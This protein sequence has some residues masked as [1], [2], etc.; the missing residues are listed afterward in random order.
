[1]LSPRERARSRAW[2]STPRRVEA[3][4]TLTELF[5]SEDLTRDRAVEE[6][7]V[8]LAELVGDGFAA[9]LLEEEQRW[10]RPLG[11]HHPERQPGE[12][13]DAIGA[14]RFRA[15]QGFSASVLDTGA[16]VLIPRITRAEIDALQPELAPV[17]EA[18]GA[19]GFIIV[20][21]TVRGRCVAL[22]AQWRTRARPRLCEDDQRFLEEVGLRFALGL[23]SWSP[24][25]A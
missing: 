12:V 11:A 24:D 18:M 9:C 14:R 23:A 2:R 8:A 22:V 10:M 5:A 21:A 13:L 17:C 6:S 16:A 25:H 19:R 15:D 20:P 4:A 1:M 3:L 7:V